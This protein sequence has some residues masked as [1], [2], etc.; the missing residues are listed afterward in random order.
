[1]GKLNT[2]DVR[3]ALEILPK[4]I[5][6]TYHEAMERIE[7]Q[8]AERREL[9]KRVLLWITFAFQPLSVKALQHALAVELDTAS[10]DPEAI[11]DDDILTSV[12]AGL[13]VV[14]GEQ[15]TICLVRE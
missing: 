7:R 12:C 1:M 2:A 4:G 3:K 11:I 14:D 10:L 15:N 6:D 13:V 5:D 8:D 9:A